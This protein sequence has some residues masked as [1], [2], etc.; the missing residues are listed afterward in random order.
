MPLARLLARLMAR[1]A[2]TKDELKGLRL[3]FAEV[4]QERLD[5]LDPALFEADSPWR[6]LVSYFDLGPPEAEGGTT[7]HAR[8]AGW[9]LVF[10]RFV[11]VPPEAGGVGCLREHLTATHGPAGARSG[12][13]VEGPCGWKGL[14]FGT[15]ALLL[16][17]PLGLSAE[18][19][20]HSVPLLLGAQ[21]RVVRPG[22]DFTVLHAPRL[23]VSPS[24]GR[25][26]LELFGQQDLVPQIGAAFPRADGHPL[27]R[28]RESCVMCHGPNGG[29]LGTASMKLPPRTDLLAPVN[30][31]EE[32]RVL[33]AKRESESFRALLRFFRD[34]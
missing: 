7:M 12:L 3:S 16:D 22:G 18:G 24:P 6:E 31:V 11:R 25:L 28:V 10:R 9:R 20:L 1:V 33:R 4:A 30:T 17:T 2:L 29:R 5:L 8:R 32:D 21:V 15:T 27:V 13:A 34:S 14:P 23:A 19:E 26:S